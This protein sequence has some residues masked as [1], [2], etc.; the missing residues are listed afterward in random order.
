MSR[1]IRRWGLIV[2]G[3]NNKQ[4]FPLA[5]LLA[6]FDGTREQA[7]EQAQEYIRNYTPRHPSPPQ[8]TRLYRTADGW[9]LIGD[10]M[11]KRQYP[12]HFRVCEL[13]SD[14]GPPP[15]EEPY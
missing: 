7:E 10:G 5:E 14:S 4:P 8:R 15:W 1:A 12:Y 2:E 9:L 3:Q 11:R 13:V 6:E